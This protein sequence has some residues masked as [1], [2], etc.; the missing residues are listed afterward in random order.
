MKCTLTAG[1]L[2]LGVHAAVDSIF[3]GETDG[4]PLYITTTAP[5]SQSRPNRLTSNHRAAYFLLDFRDQSEPA[6]HLP[7]APAMGRGY[8]LIWQ[9]CPYMEHRQGA[10]RMRQPASDTFPQIVALT[11]GDGTG[12]RRVKAITLERPRFV[13]R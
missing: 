6:L 7:G 13:P 8:D 12:S 9:L 10:N 4:D 3:T 2:F 11:L 1:L 5:V